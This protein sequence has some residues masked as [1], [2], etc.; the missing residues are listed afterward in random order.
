MGDTCLWPSASSTTANIFHFCL[1][2]F[3]TR[4][5]LQIGELVPSAHGITALQNSWSVVVVVVFVV[6]V[7]VVCLFLLVGL[8]VDFVLFFCFFF[9]FG[10]ILKH[11]SSYCTYN[12]IL[13]IM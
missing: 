8:L 11:F 9:I 4:P 6:V 7:V 5:R 2:F 12:K 1:P 3:A 10:H 13:N